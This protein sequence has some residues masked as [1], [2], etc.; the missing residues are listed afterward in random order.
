M[1]GVE[2]VGGVV[3]TGEYHV[4]PNGILGN[5]DKQNFVDV[6]DT[7]AGQ[8]IGGLRSRVVVFPP[9]QPQVTVHQVLG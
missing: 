7:G 3:L 9:D 8:P 2:G 5:R 1:V 4:G 6:G